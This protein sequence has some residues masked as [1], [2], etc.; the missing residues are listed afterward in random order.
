MIAVVRGEQSHP[1]PSSDLRLENGD[2]LV[3]VGS[4]EEID[5]AFQFL[6]SDETD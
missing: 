6:D 2:C 5:R 4:H 1:N 3:L